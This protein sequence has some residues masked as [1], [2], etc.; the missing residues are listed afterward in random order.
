MKHNVRP[1]I[2]V[3]PP[4]LWS[5]GY[6]DVQ[7]RIQMIGLSYPKWFYLTMDR[8]SPAYSNSLPSGGYSIDVAFMASTNS[9]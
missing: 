2:I 9:S 1:I 8:V 3:A 4:F 5:S 6:N 7:V